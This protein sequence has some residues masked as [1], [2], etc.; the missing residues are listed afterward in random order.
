VTNFHTTGVTLHVAQEGK[1]TPV[2]YDDNG[3][4]NSI[5]LGKVSDGTIQMVKHGLVLPT[6]IWN[7]EDP[8]FVQGELTR[9]EN[10]GDMERV[11]NWQRETLAKYLGIKVDQI[12]VA[13]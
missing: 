13:A 7:A 11:Q 9:V 10:R 6:V 5:E 4:P 12:T 3:K 2:R 1:S 8:I